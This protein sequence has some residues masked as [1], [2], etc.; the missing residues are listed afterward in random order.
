[1]K[2]SVV[3]LITLI[4]VASIA[5]V[6]YLG[7]K[8]QSYNDVIYVEGIEILNEYSVE[9]ATGAKYLYFEPDGDDRSIQ[10]NCVARPDDA[11]DVKIIYQLEKDCEI[12]TIDENGLLNFTVD[13]SKPV[14]SVK[15]YLYSNQN[16][17]ISDELTVH[18]LLIP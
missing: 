1:M 7:L 12:A 9:R 8:A 15:V 2:K 18:L 5:L 11:S 16:T 13:G 3:I 14:Y 6:G 4:Y 10:I 17:S